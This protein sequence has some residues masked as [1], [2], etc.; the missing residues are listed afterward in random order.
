MLFF[1]SI[2]FLEKISVVSMKLSLHSQLSLYPL[3]IHQDKKNYIVEDVQ[4]GDF[5]EM[6]KICL[7]AI[8]MINKGLALGVIEQE[9][10]RNYPREDVN[11]ID[12]AQQLMDLGLINEVDGEEIFRHKKA[13]PLNGFQWISPKVGK[14]FFN[15]F[16]IKIF[17]LFM[18]VN[19]ILLISNPNL[20]PQYDD[21]FQTNSITINLLIYSTISFI[22]LLVHEF[23][24]ILA[25]RSFHLPTKIGIGHRL[26]FIVLET[27]L[28]QGW[29]L[30]PK[31]RNVLY[32]AG[33]CFE[34]CIL[35]TAL[36]LKI[37]IP[38]DNSVFTGFLD[39]I[40]LDL[41]FKAVY[42]CCIYIKTDFYYVFE[43]STGC[44]NLL[45]NGKQLL[46]K[47][48]PFMKSDTTTELF[49]DEIKFARIYS[50]FYICGIIATFGMFIFYFLPQYFHSLF[51][52]ISN[53][54][55]RIATPYFWEGI[56]FIGMSM[57]M[58][59]LFIYAVVKNYREQR[60]ET[61]Q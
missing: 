30:E 34:Q 16:S 45:E 25:A 52:A 49:D 23:G 35:L 48:I 41:F 18:I 17:I 57:L 55:L 51:M 31:K 56:L 6:P 15:P 10:S 4:S 12:F 1:S 60:N 33:I 53:L 61:H 36:L 14:F 44:Y 27:D 20:R 8:D 9:L 29:K 42:Q 37:W 11:M 7:D 3:S 21:I 13:E 24:H 54:N 58:L 5:Y 59:G 46:T 28:T 22:L 19:G 50:V 47:R 2:P 39:I 32:M 26:I 40:I 38:V 43:N